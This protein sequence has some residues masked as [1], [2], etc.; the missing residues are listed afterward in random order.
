MV[1]I[2]H[3]Q[4]VG[5]GHLR[6]DLGQMLG[7]R[8]ADRDRQAELGAHA[9]ADRAGDLGRRAEQTGAAGD[10]GKRLVDGNPLDHRR[11]IAEHLNSRIAQPL[12]VL[13]MAAD[14]NQPGAELTCAPPRHA[15]THAE[16]LGL[17]GGGQHDAAAD[18]DRLAAQ[19]RIEQLLDRGIEGVEIRVE[20]V[21]FHPAR[22]PAAVRTP[23]CLE[24]VSCGT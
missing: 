14:E 19:G 22:S 2:D 4:P 3:H 10:V 11:E 9:A 20:D 13:E 21:G 17:V 7:A 18:G 23:H 12:V 6:G 24:V 5:L 16:S 1:R 8:H 15:A